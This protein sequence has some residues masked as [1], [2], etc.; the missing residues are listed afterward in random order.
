M[1]QGFSN[2]CV[3]V[4]INNRMVRAV[5]WPFMF[6]WVSVVGFLPVLFLVWVWLSGWVSIIVSV[7][8]GHRYQYEN[9][10]RFSRFGVPGF[11]MAVG[12]ACGPVCA[13]VG[14]GRWGDSQL[15]SLGGRAVD[16]GFTMGW[17]DKGAGFR[18]LG[19]QELRRQYWYGAW[20]IGDSWGWEVSWGFDLLRMCI[21]R[22]GE[23]WV[24]WTA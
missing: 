7:W 18:W 9:G 19:A 8:W 6:W 21:V 10:A 15:E 23:S 4:L 20:Y 24:F 13:Q 22:L 11:T 16:R 14:F 3:Q 2:R 17:E 5:M 12:R 1:G